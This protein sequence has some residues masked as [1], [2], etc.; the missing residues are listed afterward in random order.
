MCGRL[1]NHENHERHERKDTDDCFGENN[2]RTRILTNVHEFLCGRLKNH[3]NHE[4]HEKK[5]HGW[6]FEGK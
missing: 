3:E 6:L 5:G 4:R 2:K 1:K